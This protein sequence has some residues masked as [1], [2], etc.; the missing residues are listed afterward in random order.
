MK[1]RICAL[2]L[3]ACLPVASSAQPRSSR[4]SDHYP[5]T[6]VRPRVTRAEYDRW[7]TELSNWGRWG[8]NDQSGAL[9]LVTDVKRK[10]AAALV[11]TGVSVSLA[12]D[13]NEQ[14]AEDNPSPYQRVMMQA[15]RGGSMDQ[16]TVAFHGMAHTH[17]DALSHRVLDDKIYN[18]YSYDEVTM[19]EGAKKNS[20]YSAHNGIVTRGILIDIPALKGVPY[21][22][23]GTR[24]FGDDLEAWEK[25]AGVKVAA[26][27]AVFIRTG[28]WARRAALGP[29]TQ[30]AGLDPSVLPWLKRRDVSVLGSEL[31]LDASPPASADLPR[32]AV[33]DFALVILGIHVIDDCDLSAVSQ[34]AAQQKRWEFL[35]TVAPIPFRRGTGSPTNP[36]AVF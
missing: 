13:A 2:L 5:V 19:Q 26:G 9:N 32:L 22:D 8:T 17:I 16:F 31:A 35:V 28:R 11:H 1:T 18:G 33:H 12:V 3:A 6:K 23:P 27:D 21:L 7:K 25:R 29:Q 30:T 14:Q 34:V 36:I 15:G 20:I 24:I 4:A 10:Q